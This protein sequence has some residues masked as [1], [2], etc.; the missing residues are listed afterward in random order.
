MNYSIFFFFMLKY[1]QRFWAAIRY[2]IPLPSSIPGQFLCQVSFLNAVLLI[3]V[4]GVLDLANKVVGVPINNLAYRDLEMKTKWCFLLP[5]RFVWRKMQISSVTGHMID[6][7][8]RHNPYKE[9]YIGYSCQLF[10]NCWVEINLTW[11]TKKII[12]NLFT[13]E[14]LANFHQQNAIIW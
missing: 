1:L 11:G 10:T 3:V 12:K 6:V 2:C 13:K 4:H 8:V 7:Y 9:G 14:V 5:K